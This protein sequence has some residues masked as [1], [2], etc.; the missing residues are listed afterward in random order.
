MKLTV[1]AIAMLISLC[2]TANAQ[3]LVSKVYSWET[4]PVKSNKTG[5]SKKIFSGSGLTLAKHEINGVSLLKG[6]SIVYKADANGYE[7]FLIIKDGP[8]T[9]YLND[10]VSVIDRGSIVL[11][12]P[13]DKVSVQNAGDETAEFYEINYHSIEPA[14]HERGR[15][16]GAS[17]VIN[18]NKLV[19]KPTTKG[20]TRQVADRQTTML[21]NLNIHVTQLN[22]GLKSH[23]PHTHKNEEIMLML[24]GNAEVQI[25]AEHQKAN[26]GDLVFLGS[27]VLHNI[28]NIGK[29]PCLYY[30]IQ[31]N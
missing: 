15:D 22:A 25:G 24:D 26:A 31:W 3:P 12:L 5:S 6:K 19:V 17:F 10:E 28:T 27:T 30:A 16:A 21:N 29:T 11:I 23:E 14:N 18:W 13:G 1:L 9:V 8:V 2:N 20:N 4:S 7:R